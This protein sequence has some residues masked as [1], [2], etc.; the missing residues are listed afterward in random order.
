MSVG[1]AGMGGPG[2]G[3]RTQKGTP[4]PCVD[5]CYEPKTPSQN[6]KGCPQHHG[7]QDPMSRRKIQCWH[8]NLQT[9]V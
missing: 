6:G 7:M 5:P 8:R 9:P 2:S 4:G 3:D 1:G